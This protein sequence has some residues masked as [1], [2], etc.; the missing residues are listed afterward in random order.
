MADKNNDIPAEIR[1]VKKKNGGH[2]GHH[3]GA[4]KVA[5]ADFVTAMMAFFL[6]MWIVGLSDNVREA[7]AAY[8]ED[9]VKFMESVKNGDSP[10]SV[11]DAL[12]PGDGSGME[13]PAM[14]FLEKAKLAKAK[15]KLEKMVA[16]NPEFEKIKDYV[17]IKLVAEGLRVDLVEGK[18]NLFFDSGC[19]RIKPETKKLLGK[20]AQEFGT[21]NSKI[22]IEGHTDS[23]PLA[24]ADGYTN[25]ELSADRANSARR[26]MQ[27]SGLKKDQVAQVRGYADTRPR[28]KEDTTH[29]S[30]RRVSIVVLNSEGRKTHLKDTGEDAPEV[31]APY[32]GS[33]ISI[34][35]GE[36]LKLAEDGYVPKKE[37]DINKPSTGNASEG[38]SISGESVSQP[39]ESKAHGK[40]RKTPR[41]D[42]FGTSSPPFSTSKVDN[43]EDVA[44]KK[45]SGAKNTS[46]KTRPKKDPH[47]V[48]HEVDRYGNKKTH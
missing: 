15:K 44:A 38:T 46:T 34:E 47:G 18:E 10:F 2:E 43:P 45:N 16:E 11:Q 24:R 33:D 1:V 26:V 3:G 22:I 9:P 29:F 21:L 13:T 28:N 7:V 41:R 5:Y 48:F 37:V 14:E 39:A 8:F 6:V 12:A 23:R 35:N 42:I 27:G 36:S 4:W 19:A 25:W 17:K 31:T 32:A 20:M 40:M 30:N